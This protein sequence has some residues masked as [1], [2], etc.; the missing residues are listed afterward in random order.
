MHG[1]ESEEQQKFYIKIGTVLHELF[2]KIKTK[3]D[4]ESVLKQLELDGVLYDE[5]ISKEKIEKMLRARLNSPLVSE[6]FSDKWKVLNETSILYLDK[7][8]KVCQDRPD[9]V[10]VGENEII[11]IDFK[12]GKPH[13]D[14]HDQVRQYM[15]QLKGMGYSCVKGYL[16]YVYPNKVENV[17][18][19]D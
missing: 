12:F 8:G 19:E 11:V 15:S 16:W 13:T 1:D 17:V 10:L 9:R 6:W 3:D 7:D 18:L 2:S 5:N 4:V 14:Y